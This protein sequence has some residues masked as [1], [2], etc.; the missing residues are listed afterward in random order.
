MRR[1]R[2]AAVVAVGAAAAVLYSNFLFSTALP[3]DKAWKPVVSEMEVPGTRHALALR[4]SDVLCAALV[5][6][7]LPFLH[8]A[9]PAGRKR[10]WA[11]G[12]TAV[13][14]VGNAIAGI[15]TL[16]GHGD[17][18][19]DVQRWIHNASS[20]V[21]AGAVFLG[22]LMIALDRD[23][24]RWA[25]T[26][27]GLAFW[28]GGVVGGVA[29]GVAT[30]IDDDSVSTGIAQRSQILVTSCWLV[31]LGVLAAQPLRRPPKATDADRVT[32][33]A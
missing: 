14:A 27:A 13:F 22:A 16:P 24:A 30:V 25:R 1:W 7:L 8:R 3:G 28:I 20:V 23:V 5:L 4:V 21:S 32:S 18:H 33:T 12:S 6:V 26:A 31:C 9:L 19:D 29:L 11:I 15:V 17:R 2:S 10:A